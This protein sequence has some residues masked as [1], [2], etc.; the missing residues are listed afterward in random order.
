MNKIFN[1][2]LTIETIL[3]AQNGDENSL[4]IIFNKYHPLIDKYSRNYHLKNFDNDDLKQEGYL[5]I[6]NAINK[7][8]ID[9][10][11]T[12][13]D[14]YV[15]VSIRNCYVTLARNNIKFNDEGS[16]NLTIDNE[17]NLMNAIEDTSKDSNIEETYIKYIDMANIVQALYSLDISEKK[18]INSIFFKEKGSL[19]KYCNANNITYYKGKQQ[20]NSI[21]NKLRNSTSK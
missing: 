19:L 5:A 15:I 4:L 20:L 16:L 13:F 21:I 12:S 8:N 9:K 7:Y 11:I 3:N 10:G 1:K 14:S 17:L 18:M 2:S 6:I